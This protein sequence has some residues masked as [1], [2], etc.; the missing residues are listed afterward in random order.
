M[1]IDEQ[2]LSRERLTS[3]YNS[4]FSNLLTAGAAAK[5]QSEMGNALYN[6]LLTKKTGINTQIAPITKYK[7]RPLTIIIEVSKP[8]PGLLPYTQT[9]T[10]TNTHTHT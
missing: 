10:H 3:S 6:L 7:S 9:P 1:I 8:K 4:E 2:S 5:A